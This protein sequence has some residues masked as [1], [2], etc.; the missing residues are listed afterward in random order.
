LTKT[1]VD[2]AQSILAGAQPHLRRGIREPCRGAIDAVMRYQP[3]RY[4]G[5]SFLSPVSN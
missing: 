2:K 3:K 4:R 5:V 1:G